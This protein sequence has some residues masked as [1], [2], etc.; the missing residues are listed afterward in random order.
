MSSL[1]GRERLTGR[2][3]REDEDRVARVDGKFV[4]NPPMADKARA[5]L[6]L[7]VAASLDNILMVEGEMKEVTEDDMLEA[8]K[9]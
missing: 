5:D 4:V 2:P 9:H 6:D 8:L 3:V 1:L 7:I